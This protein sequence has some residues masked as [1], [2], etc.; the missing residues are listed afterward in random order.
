MN[1]NRD[2]RGA[3]L[4]IVLLLVATLSFVLLSLT[5]TV[6]TG[7]RRGGAERARADLLW[8]AL[9]AERIALQILEKAASAGAL[10]TASSEG[11]LFKQQVALPVGRGR[12]ALRLADASRCFNVNSLIGSSPPYAKQPKEYGEFVRLLEAIGAGNS[13]AA[14]IADSL[15]DFM[16]DDSGTE[17][18]GS[19]D[20]FYTA[21]TTPFRT[22]GGPIASVSELRAVDGVTR[23]IYTRIARFL[24]ARGAGEKIVVN[25]NALTP[26]DAPLIFALAEGNWPLGD[27]RARIAETPPGGWTGGAAEF[28]SLSPAPT[29][30]G[31]A[32]TNDQSDWIEARVLLEAD[33]RIVE[34]ALIIKVAAPGAGGGKPTLYSRVFGGGI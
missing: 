11:G 17:S 33:E 2:Q 9:A 21:L 22:A 19:E 20:N 14:A 1:A 13:E 3:A 30:P 12:A 16:D 4:V 25:V 7:V 32:R 31:V 5:T 18:Q 15:T 28:W 23:K 24:C 34:E 29:G 27:V 10:K 8:R 6:T 26:D